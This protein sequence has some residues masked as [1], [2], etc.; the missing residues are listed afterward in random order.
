MSTKKEKINGSLIQ[1][2]SIYGSIGQDLSIYKGTEMEENM[3][4]AVIKGGVANLTRQMASYYGKYNIRINTLCAGG[5]EGHVAGSS[6][7]Q[8]SIFIK[9]YSNKTPLKRLGR[10]DEIASTALFLASDA[11]SYITGSTLFVDGGITI[12]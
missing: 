8:D 4:Y 3:T 12:I 11:S 7:A 6:H 1:L 9:N 5:I 10:S 2:G